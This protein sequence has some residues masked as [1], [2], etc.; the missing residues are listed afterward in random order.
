MA[1][2]DLDVL[3]VAAGDARIFLVGGAV[4]DLALGREDRPDL[5][6]AVEGDVA[7]L[8]GRLG[9]E[10]VHHDRFRTAIVRSG[11]L[12]VDLAATRAETYSSPGALPEVEPARLDE[13]LARRD[14]TVNAMAVPLFG[15]PQ[16][17]DPHGGFADL[18][19]SLLRV[20]HSDS[21]SDDPT[22]VLRGAR[23][24]ARLGLDLDQ[25]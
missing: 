22:R 12:R 20:L 24:G 11:D 4:R 16:L 17:I 7:E 1:Q 15:Q 25:A 3:C 23:Y 14:F 19:S 6:V 21:F 5:D 9:G 10:V 13:D 18:E 8:A 2:L